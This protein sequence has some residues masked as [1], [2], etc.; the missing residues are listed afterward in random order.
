M[1]QT[2]MDRIEELT[3]ALV[4]GALTQAEGVELARLLESD[5]DA[6]RVYL[7]TLEVEVDLR[8]TRELPDLTGPTM[9]RLRA[10]LG[11]RLAA[12]VMQAIRSRPSPAWSARSGGG[13]APGRSRRSS[14][15]GQRMLWFA[16][17]AAA[18]LALAVGLWW[19]ASRGRMPSPGSDGA[20]DP[21]V[22]ATVVEVPGV[23]PSERFNAWVR[24][25][26]TRIA[27]EVGGRLIAGDE[28]IVQ[29][30][31]GTALTLEYPDG[32]R[33][34]CESGSFVFQPAATAGAGGG[35]RLHLNDALV[36]AVV[37]PQTAGRPMIV[38][39][40]HARME[41]LGTRL[42]IISAA[43]KTELTVRE[44]AVRLTRLADARSVQVAAGQTAVASPSEDL[45][46]RPIPPPPSWV[47]TFGAVAD[48]YVDQ[49]NP[50]FSFGKT[51]E[52]R[53]GRHNVRESVNAYIRFVCG[54]NGRVRRAVLRLTPTVD[55]EGGT[56]LLAA[57]DD[58][59]ELRMNFHHAPGVRGDA[60]ATFG[61]TKRGEPVDVDVTSAVRAGRTVTF[62]VRSDRP[63][64][65]VF[66]SRES[67]H[68]GPRLVVTFEEP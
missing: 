65:G 42:S 66:A 15:A 68:G 25:G 7:S 20:A 34:A 5:P 21:T 27:A 32:T 50:A 4:D 2:V 35:K 3:L 16:A 26:G 45:A 22:A 52:L 55:G 58:W 41:V 9:E 33:L 11:D 29:P 1:R 51:V 39:T 57:A 24:R 56:V 40:R 6:A 64:G 47:E 59:D 63:H 44:G 28:V 49:H 62:L 23:V 60:I 18:L 67:V 31:P 36:S 53:V 61:A 13:G 38:T 30:A 12:G 54:D 37:A 8:G 48:A 17:S 10:D 14:G 19:Y 46:V 43:E